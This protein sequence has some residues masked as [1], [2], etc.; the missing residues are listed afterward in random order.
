MNIISQ[1]VAKH[2]EIRKK[3][4]EQ[5]MQNMFSD[6]K[7]TL[8]SLQ[9]NTNSQ[10]NIAGTSTMNP[11]VLSARSNMKN[12][13]EPINANHRPVQI[14]S[15]PIRASLFQ[16]HVQVTPTP[17]VTLMH[18][19]KDI[20]L[21]KAVPVKEQ[22]SVP[23]QVQQTEQAPSAVNIVQN[24]EISPGKNGI[25]TNNTLDQPISYSKISDSTQ[26]AVNTLIEISGTIYEP[27]QKEK[28]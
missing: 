27:I 25:H 3:L 7:T 5:H 2:D 24:E 26:F 28:E 22:D 14:V 19:S 8:M 20:Q 18:S 17:E 10:V 9:P 23:Q 15:E 1:V 12:Q 6:L 11:I 13:N 16:D 4:H 21:E